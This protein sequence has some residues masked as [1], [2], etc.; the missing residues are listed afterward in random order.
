MDAPPP[1]SR[2][3]DLSS[4]PLCAC[5]ATHAAP[6]DVRVEEVTATSRG[7]GW[8]TYGTARTAAY[9]PSCGRVSEAI[10]YRVPY[11]LRGLA[12]PGCHQ[13]VEY[14]VALRCVTAATAGFSF[15]AIVTC[16]GCTRR[17]TFQRLISTLSHLRRIKISPTSLEI[18][19]GREQG[20]P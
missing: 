3:L 16:T 7:G 5:R 20:T 17:S 15:T 12:C 9:C 1:T 2:A 19:L 13:R 18:D 8:T 6:I 14:R 4:E 10:T 11:E